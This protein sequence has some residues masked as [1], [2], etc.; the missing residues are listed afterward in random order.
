M[1][2]PTDTGSNYC[3]RIARIRLKDSGG[4]PIEINKTADITLFVEYRF[5]LITV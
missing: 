2:T 4:N 5:T 1:D 3:G